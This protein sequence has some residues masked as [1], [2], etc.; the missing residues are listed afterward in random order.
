MR[1]REKP[2][3]NNSQPFHK[4]RAGIIVP[5]RININGQIGIANNITS[6][7]DAYDPD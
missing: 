3:T 1:H 2:G 4:Y 5:I 6:I 7:I